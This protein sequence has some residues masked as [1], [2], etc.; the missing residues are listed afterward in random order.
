MRARHFSPLPLLRRPALQAGLLLG[1][2]GLLAASFPVPLLALLAAAAAAAVALFALAFPT[3]ATVVWLLLAGTTPDMWLG[4]LLGGHTPEIIAAMKFAGLFLVACCASRWCV[5]PDPF[6]PGLPFL[7]MFATGLVSG[8]LPGLSLTESLRSLLGSAAPFAFSFVNLPRRWSRAVARVVQFVPLFALLV[9]VALGA[10]GIKPLFTGQAGIRL[11]GPGHPAFLAGFALAGIWASLLAL[12]IGGRRRDLALLGL[13]FAI[14][15]LTGARAPLAIA[16]GVTLVAVLAVPSPEFGWRARL[17]L[18]VGAGFVA[19]LLVVAALAGEGGIRILGILRGDEAGL[20]GR[21][22][23]WPLFT[24]AWDA[25][26][27]FGWGVGAGKVL[28]PEDDT[29]ARMLG[30]T[31]AHN[32]YLRIGV[33]GG[34]VGLTM[35]IASFGLWTWFH[36]R[37]LPPTERRVLRLVM[38]GFA[39]HAYTD[40]VLI[41]TTASVLFTWMSA[42]FAGGAGSLARRTQTETPRCAVSP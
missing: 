27:W 10:S 30:T 15:V 7:A 14:L 34:W 16:V 37:R 31:A 17:P 6:N 8:L 22:I 24:R 28:V 12:F 26:P 19:I 4:D 11:A 35:L 21:D 23:I 42:A 38:T 40:N 25:S 13:N 32:E 1:A 39:I 5:R 2:A 36:T 20:S 41:A 29:L 33:D 9:G 3:A 18:L